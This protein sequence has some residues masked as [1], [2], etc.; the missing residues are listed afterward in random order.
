M[1]RIDKLSQL[2]RIPVLTFHRRGRSGVF[3][4]KSKDHPF[5][6]DYEESQAFTRSINIRFFPMSHTHSSDFAIYYVLH[7]SDVLLKITHILV[8]FV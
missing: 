3:G 4:H 6:L 8:H 2:C 7:N 1:E 5:T